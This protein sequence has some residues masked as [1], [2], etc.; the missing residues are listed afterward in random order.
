[1]SID[2]KEIKK[3][4]IKSIITSQTSINILLSRYDLQKSYKIILNLKTTTFENILLQDKLSL[5]AVVGEGMLTMP[6]VAAK[7]FSAVSAHRINVT[8]IS[9]GASP[10]ATYFVVKNSDKELAIKAIHDEFFK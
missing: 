1:M 7:I 2:E 5:I 4:N 3:I 8:I 10:V 9:A 6:G